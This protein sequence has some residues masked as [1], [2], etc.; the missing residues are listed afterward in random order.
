MMLSYRHGYHVGNRADVLKHTVLV[1]CLCHLV[2]KSRPSLFLDAF[3]GAGSYRLGDGY[4]EKTKEWKDGIGRLLDED[5]S[6]PSLISAYLEVVKRFNGEAAVQ[7]ERAVDNGKKESTFFHY[8]GSPAL[9]RAFARA[10]DRLVL[11]DLHGSEIDN[12]RRLFR[13][14]RHCAV[15]KTDGVQGLIAE[16]PPREKRGLFFVDPSYEMKDDWD[17]VPHGVLK[18]W[19]RFSAG[20]FVVWYPVI[21]RARA[22]NLV[23]RFVING[24]A[25]CYQVEMNW[26]S[27]KTDKGMTGAGLLLINPPYTLAGAVEEALPWLADR[28]GATGPCF[29]RQLTDDGGNMA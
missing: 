22:E 15:L 24:V 5:T 16:T 11:H 29:G 28:L 25:K 3:A 17:R 7:A 13:N 23:A 9:M 14:R 1:H 19:R 26:D 18:A 20:L 4:S 8:P 6:P 2:Q 27:D 10:E 21:E 12:L